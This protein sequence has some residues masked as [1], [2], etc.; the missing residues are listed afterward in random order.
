[1]NQ[2]TALIKPK[3]INA[4]LNYNKITNNNSPA[5]GIQRYKST[6]QPRASTTETLSHKAWGLYGPCQPS[7][8]PEILHHYYQQ[9]HIITGVVH[10][11]NT[12]LWTGSSTI[13]KYNVHLCTCIHYSHL[14]PLPF[15]C[16]LWNLR[17]T[18]WEA[19]DVE[20]RFWDTVW[21]VVP[22]QSWRFIFLPP[23]GSLSA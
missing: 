8:G 22:K 11:V 19:L 13:S 10:A 1:M 17:T 4:Q 6:G 2:T 3:S 12:H 21:C 15:E 23:V 20:G 18:A 16:W 14:S 9:T 5:S 7:A